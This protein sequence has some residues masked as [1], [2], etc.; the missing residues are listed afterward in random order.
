MML[1]AFIDDSGRG[2]GAQFIMA[3]FL[4][5]VEKWLHF[6]HAWQ[7]ALDQPPKLEYLK[8]RAAMARIPYGPFR[9]W[10]REQCEERIDR[11]VSVIEDHSLIRIR[12]AVPRKHYDCIFRGKIAPSM[13]YPHFL[14]TYSVIME[15]NRFLSFGGI[16]EKVNFVFDEESPRE[17]RPIHSAWEFYA[18]FA[19]T[20]ARPLIGNPPDF[21]DDKEVL[22]L[23]A[24]DLYAWHARQYGESRA[25]GNEYDHPVWHTLSSL[26]GIEREWNATDL[27]E[28]VSNVRQ[29]S[30]LNNRTLQ[31]DAKRQRRGRQRDESHFTRVR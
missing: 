27:A 12:I 19:P 20:H 16:R 28:M 4:T 5:T 3:G 26:T 1:Q 6:N 11:L 10:G 13:D 14:P 25:R 21:G 24:A 29:F 23:Q 17:Q 22:P 9:G 7:A 15:T 31:Y 30:I 2:Q 8:T 18:R